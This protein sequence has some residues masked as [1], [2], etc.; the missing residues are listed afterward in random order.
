MSKQVKVLKTENNTIVYMQSITDAVAY[1]PSVDAKAR[2]NE[3]EVLTTYLEEL[4]DDVIDLEIIHLEPKIRISTASPVDIEV[5]TSE[6]ISITMTTTSKGNVNSGNSNFKNVSLRYKIGDNEEII[7]TNGTVNTDITFNGAKNYSITASGTADYRGKK[8]T[9]TNTSAIVSAVKKSYM[10]YIESDNVD[11]VKDKFTKPSET[12][13]TD[14]IKVW[15]K[16]SPNGTYQITAKNDGYLV[17]AIPINGNAGKV[18]RI[19][20]QGTVSANQPFTTVTTDSFTLYICS[21]KHDAG[22]YTFTI[23]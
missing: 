7:D 11:G 10:T 15:A 14:T 5:T 13:S 16:T 20:Q 6:D 3:K 19:V 22:T 2:G 18:N 17:V 21:T 12:A 23:N 4:Q 1:T 9:F 8:V